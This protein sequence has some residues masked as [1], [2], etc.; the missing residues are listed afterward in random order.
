MAVLCLEGAFIAV[1]FLSQWLSY[2]QIYFIQQ[3]WVCP[4]K[5]DSGGPGIYVVLLLV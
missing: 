5:L 2:Y 3:S 1:D 4:I